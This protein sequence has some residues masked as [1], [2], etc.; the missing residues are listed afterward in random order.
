VKFFWQISGKIGLNFQK[1][2]K[3]TTLVIA[4]WKVTTF[5][6]AVFSPLPSSHIVYPVSFLNSATKNLL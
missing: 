2:S 1:F 4:L 6:A 5:L 3:L